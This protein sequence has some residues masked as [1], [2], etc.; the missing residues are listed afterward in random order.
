MA[1]VRITF[2][3]I[4]SWDAKREQVD[5]ILEDATGTADHIATK[6]LPPII[7]GVDLEQD[8]IEKLKALEGVVVKLQDE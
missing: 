3:S 1:P 5:R 8:A 6:S 4:E 2:D 7:V